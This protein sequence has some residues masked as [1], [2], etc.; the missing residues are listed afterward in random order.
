MTSK[1]TPKAAVNTE[2]TVEE[3]TVPQQAAGSEPKEKVTVLKGKS[4]DGKDAI[5]VS[6]DD[7]VD[8]SFKGKFLRTIRNKK[9]LAGLGTVAA[10]A[11]FGI[12]K[13][14]MSEDDVTVTT[15]KDDEGH[16][17]SVTVTTN[18]TE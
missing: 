18:D 8:N 4:E 16:I 13:G 2:E 14:L 9:V 12:V 7:E 5:F 1:N 17:T 3:T 11:I 10:I 15:E 6:Y